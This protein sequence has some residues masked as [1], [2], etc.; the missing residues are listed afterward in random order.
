MTRTDDIDNDN[1]E[2]RAYDNDKFMI[3]D[4][5]LVKSGAMT[6]TD[7]SDKDR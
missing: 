3:C 1:D 6:E 7:N 5:D 4:D 2:G